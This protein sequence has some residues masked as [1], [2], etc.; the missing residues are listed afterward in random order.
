MVGCHGDFKILY[1]HKIMLTSNTHE[2]FTLLRKLIDFFG[3]K[4][5]PLQ[6]SKSHD[7]PIYK[8][9]HVLKGREN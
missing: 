1:V 9:M 7:I 6:V 3:E 5:P 4:F 8:I 2:K